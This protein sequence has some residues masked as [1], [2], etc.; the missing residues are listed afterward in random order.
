MLPTPAAVTVGSV[1]TSPSNR[2]TRSTSARSSG[3]GVSSNSS[4][5]VTT[6]P[7]SYPPSSASSAPTLRVSSPAPARR[8]TASAICPATRLARRCRVAGDTARP[9]PAISSLPRLPN[10]P[11]ADAPPQASATSNATIEAATRIGR[12]R[13]ISGRRG[14]TVVARALNS[15]IPAA[16]RARPIVRPAAARIR[17][18][19]TAILTSC[20]VPAPSA[21]RSANSRRR[22]TERPISIVMTLRQATIRTSPA[23]ACA[24]SSAGRRSPVSTSSRRF[25]T[26]PQSSPR[27]SRLMRLASCVSCTCVVPDRSL[28]T[29]SNRPSDGSRPGGGAVHTST[30]PEGNPNAS[31]ITATISNSSSP[32]ASVCPTTSLSPAICRAILLLTTARRS[33]GA[34]RGARP[35]TAPTRST[36]KKFSLTHA[37]AV[38]RAGPFPRTLLSRCWTPAR[39][40]PRSR[41]DQSRYQSARTPP[42]RSPPWVSSI[43]TR[44]SGSGYGSGRHNTV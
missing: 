10:A 43:V 21:C 18:S 19:T 35:R 20:I 36:S 41:S 14:S 44:R 38:I 29:S 4:R 12:S 27:N 5:A 17:P 26:A 13:P 40:A 30:A 33:P 2:F 39:S 34:R 1:R 9:A 15:S 3:N 16:A 8:T 22:A 42:L 32:T 11:T 6:R 31:G 7:V 24:A 28:A 23:A 25:V 37:V